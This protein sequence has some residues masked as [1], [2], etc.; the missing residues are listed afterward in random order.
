MKKVLSLL[1]PH[2]GT[3]TMSILFA[4]VSA[5][6]QLLLPAY[7]RD[8]Q[9]GIL[10]KEMDEIVR[11]SLMMLG[12]SAIGV[13][14]SILNTYFST[15]T[16][17]GYSITL[18][19]YIFDKVSHLSQ[20]DVDK[21]GVASLVTRTTNDVRQIHNVVLDTLKSLLPI[22]IMLV[23][24]LVMAFSMNPQVAKIS[25]WVI[26]V[27][28]VLT[29]ALLRSSSRSTPRCRSWWTSSTRLCGKRSAASA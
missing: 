24:G 3:L 17:V 12:F 25:L 20:S 6:M 29:I 18:R 15:K 16:S 5:V 8:L 21:I 2:A 9:M 10:N 23:G 11:Y 1:K 14:T 28:A 7:T 22:P 4:A 27:L 26:P 19:N 13:V